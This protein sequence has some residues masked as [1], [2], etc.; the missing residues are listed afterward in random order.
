MEK[1]A[2]YKSDKSTS[3]PFHQI[4]HH[5][6][7]RLPQYII[8]DKVKN[9]NNDI[10]DTLCGQL[11]IHHLDSTPHIPKMNGVVEAA[12]KNIKTILQKMTEPIGIGT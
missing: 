4:Q 12:N 3:D 2:R 7:I 11:K 6:T 1:L 9:L 10:M 8:K 5:L